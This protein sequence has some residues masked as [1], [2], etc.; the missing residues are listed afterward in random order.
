MELGVLSLEERRLRGHFITL[1]LPE[2]KLQ[3]GRCRSLF[4]F[5]SSGD[6]TEG[7]ENPSC[8]SAVWVGYQVKFPHGKAG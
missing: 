2:R 7:K 3:Q 1:Q 8:A 5:F 6:M 4:F